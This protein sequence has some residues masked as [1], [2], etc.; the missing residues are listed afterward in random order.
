LRICS[1][2]VSTEDRSTAAFLAGF[3][4]RPQT[5]L[6]LPSLQKNRAQDRGRVALAL[7]AAPAPPPPPQGRG[8]ACCKKFR[9]V[10]SSLTPAV[11][12]VSIVKGPG[13]RGDVERHIDTP[14]T[15]STVQ[16]REQR[17]RVLTRSYFTVYI[18]A[19]LTGQHI[20]R[21]VQRQERR[22]QRAPGVEET[23]KTFGQ[24]TIPASGYL[25][26]KGQ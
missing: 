1:P 26:R 13:N 8:S 5:G 24:Q 11:T 22:A 4:A 9:W 25:P 12:A 10:G 7:L 16:P 17:T 3:H 2:F 18:T 6:P 19:A 15:Q 21:R 20:K 23:T 14:S